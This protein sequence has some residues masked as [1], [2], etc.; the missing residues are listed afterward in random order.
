MTI[1]GVAVVSL[2]G[3]HARNIRLMN[4]SQDMN[5]AAMLA[6]RLTASTRARGAPDLGTTQGD[7]DEGLALRTRSDREF[8]TTSEDRFVWQITVEPT[9]EPT[10]REV[11]VSVRLRG[12]EDSL[13]D[14]TYLSGDTGR[15]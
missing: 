10:I 7:F 8:T 9:L 4:R 15:R 13:V 12:E 2:A 1:L 11:T 6:S 14:L 5:V 3:L